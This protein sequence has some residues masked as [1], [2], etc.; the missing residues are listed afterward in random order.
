MPK[1]QFG[2]YQLYTA[3]INWR[4]GK[5]LTDQELREQNEVLVGQYKRAERE[6]QEARDA[7]LDA[8]KAANAAALEELHL[9]QGYILLKSPRIPY[10]EEARQSH[11]TGDVTALIDVQQGTIVNVTASGPTIFA[12]ATSSWI[13]NNWKFSPSANGRFT[14][15]VHFTLP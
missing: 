8:T 2:A 4:G 14:L 5:I 10:P 13:K 9:K 11:I 15:P 12:D 6:A 1:N 3:Q 7:A